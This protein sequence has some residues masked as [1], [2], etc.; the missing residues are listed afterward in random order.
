MSKRIIK[1]AVELNLLNS[2]TDGYFKGQP[3]QILNCKHHRIRT[4]RK[5]LSI[6]H[7]LLHISDNINK[8]LFKQE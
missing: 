3:H 1:S 5:Y 2:T 7:L 6:G 8:I 4:E